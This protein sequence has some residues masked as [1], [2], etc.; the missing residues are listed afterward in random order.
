AKLYTLP[1]QAPGVAVS[2][3][4]PKAARLA[5]RIGDGLITTSPNEEL[6]EIFRNSGGADKPVSGSLKVCW[7]QQAEEGAVT[8]HLLW[9]TES[10]PGELNQILPTPA[11]FEQAATL[12][13]REMVAESVPHGPEPA[14]YLRAIEQYRAAGFDELYLAQ[15]GPQQEGFFDFAAKRLLPELHQVS[16]C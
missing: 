12:V 13:T 14:G 11:H 5:G 7:A 10:L 3:F 15:I 16:S 6:I 1:A 4:G 8:A 9:P 2:A